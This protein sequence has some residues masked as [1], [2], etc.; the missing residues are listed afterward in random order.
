MSIGTGAR[1]R[2]TYS[3]F[4]AP[5][6]PPCLSV[7]LRRTQIL[8][9]NNNT[10]K[11]EALQPVEAGIHCAS[12]AL[13][14]YTVIY[15]VAHATKVNCSV[16]E[17]LKRNK[18]LTNNCSDANWDL[19]LSH[20]WVIP[21]HHRKLSNKEWKCIEDRFEKK[22]SCWKGKL[23]SYGGRLVLI[24][25]VLTSLPM[26]LLYFFEIPVGVRKRLDFYRSRFFGKV[27]R[28]RRNTD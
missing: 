25:S 26:F 21:I 5:P 16:L 14:P 3:I 7:F 19:Y 13:K 6:Q 27:V 12:M 23:M 10:N 8:N 2:E 18:M 9:Q 20:I 1:W 11:V 17:G 4:R 22:L 28:I 15:K 24:N